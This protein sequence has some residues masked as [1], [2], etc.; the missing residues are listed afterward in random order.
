MSIKRKDFNKGN[1]V[2][3]VTNR[4]KHPIVIFLKKNK[5]KAFRV[6]EIV[7]ATKVRVFATRS[8]LRKLKQTKKVLHKAP[9]FTWK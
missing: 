9:Y 7:K 2:Q 1:F 4:D 6:D 5:D 8:L 3:K